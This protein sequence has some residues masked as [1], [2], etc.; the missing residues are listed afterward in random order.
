MI[1]SK[2]VKS[3][4]LIFGMIASVVGM[5]AGS[6]SFAADSTATTTPA[7]TYGPLVVADA[8]SYRHCHNL[9]R[10][11]YCHKAESLPQNWP[12][13]SDTPH[14]SGYESNVERDCTP[15]SRRCPNNT[16]YGKG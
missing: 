4:S 16:R 14:R 5:N 3:S 2:K 10:R 1:T 12:P 6:M 15:G 11:A 13:N 7:E 8:H 9:S